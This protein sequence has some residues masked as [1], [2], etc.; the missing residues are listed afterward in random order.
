[1]E[2]DEVIGD[3]FL[4]LKVA[5]LTSEAFVEDSKEPKEKWILRGRPTEKAL[6][7]AAIEIGI[8]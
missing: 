6:L 2:V 1:M 4:A 8:N 5:A 7:K 3:K